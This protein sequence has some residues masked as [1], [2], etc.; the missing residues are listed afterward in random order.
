[1]RIYIIYR[2][3]WPDNTSYARILRSIAERFARDG[4]DVTVFAAQPSYNDIRQAQ[5]PMREVVGG[6]TI[7][8]APLLWERK[9]FLPSRVANSA[10]FMLGSLLYGVGSER[11]D[12]VM[13]VSTPPA[14]MG[15]TAR[16]LA[17]LRRTNYL[18]HTQDL[19]PEIGVIGDKLREGWFYEVMRRIELATCRNATAVVVL[20][21]DMADSVRARGY[22]GD[23]V[24]VLNNF[25]L[26]Q[27]EAVHEL[28]K[29]LEPREGKFRVLFAGNL[30]VFQGLEHVMEAAHLVA[31][32][33]N[34]EFLFLGEGLAKAGLMKDAKD[35]L[36]KTVWFHDQVSVETAVRVMEQSD[37]GLVPLQPDVYKYAYPSKAMMLLSAGLPVLVVVE[38]TSQLSKFVAQQRIGWT[39][40]PKNARAI[41]TAIREAFARRHEI[42]TQRAK[43]RS[44]AEREFGRDA[45]LHRWSEL[46]VA[47]AR[48]SSARGHTW[49]AARGP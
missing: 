42:A 48:G 44:V 35:L 14:F 39:C 11:P 31:D 6:V 15:A 28:P 34:I 30:G 33:P 45:L 41:A 46:V 13:T 40:P 26:E 47:L 12:L 17:G 22:A 36:G 7:I 24:H 1:M 8:R 10:L 20:S 9:S 21:E 4:H 43:A 25:L 3:Y 5:R 27:Y 37:L 29:A 2:H 23:N 19:H 16:L 18:Y 32:E 38:D 49:E